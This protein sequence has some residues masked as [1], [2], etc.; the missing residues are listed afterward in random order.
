MKHNNSGNAAYMPREDYYDGGGSLGYGG[1][2]DM[3]GCRRL[4][5]VMVLV[6]VAVIAALVGGL[7]SI[8]L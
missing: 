3:E 4:F 1:Q 2:R 8:F 7:L 5:I 6:V